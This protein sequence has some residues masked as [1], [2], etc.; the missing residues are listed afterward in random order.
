MGG[1]RWKAAGTNMDEDTQ[2]SQC[3]GEILKSNFLVVGD[4][5]C[6]LP[7]HTTVPESLQYLVSEGSGKRGKL[8]EVRERWRRPNANSHHCSVL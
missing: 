3:W 7:T 2:A 4:A 8:V 1:D 5:V 6:P